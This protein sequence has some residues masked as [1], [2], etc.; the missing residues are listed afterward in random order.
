MHSIVFI[1]CK[2]VRSLLTFGYAVFIHHLSALWSRA[3]I[4]MSG[5]FSPKI[6]VLIEGRVYL[7]LKFQII[8]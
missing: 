2:I 5:T 3:S 6:L 4:L 8:F 7:Y 1:L